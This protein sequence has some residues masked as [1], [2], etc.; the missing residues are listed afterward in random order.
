MLQI[1][2][3]C[4]CACILCCC[5]FVSCAIV[6]RLFACLPACPGQYLSVYSAC[7][8]DTAE[9]A[10]RDDCDPLVVVF[11]PLLLSSSSPRC[12]VCD[13]GETV[14]CAPRLTV[15]EWVRC[16]CVHCRCALCLCALCALNQN[17]VICFPCMAIRS[18]NTHCATDFPSANIAHLSL[19][20]WQKDFLVGPRLISDAGGGGFA[21][22]T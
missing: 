15:T 10:P 17:N 5:S 19:S 8:I 7:V 6:P 22:G 13:M 18:T 3:S 21:K 2:F 14:L 9:T 1:Q 11:F 16:A 4:V 12:C 20:V